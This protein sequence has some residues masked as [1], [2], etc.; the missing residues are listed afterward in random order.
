VFIEHRKKFKELLMRL[1]KKLFIN[2]LETL[3]PIRERTDG[4]FHY[5]AGVK[6]FLVS[7]KNVPQN[8]IFVFKAINH[9]HKVLKHYNFTP[10]QIVG[11]GIFI[12]AIDRL[13]LKTTRDD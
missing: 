13:P 7:V 1:Q 11:I 3:V 5:Q 12:F 9:L 10:P 6:E 8:G 2:E 4:R